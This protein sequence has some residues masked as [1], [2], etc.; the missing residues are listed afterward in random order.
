MCSADM[1][2]TSHRITDDEIK[3]ITTRPNREEELNKLSGQI[4]A[5]IELEKK[6]KIN[7]YDKLGYAGVGLFYW[8]YCGCLCTLPIKELDVVH[9]ICFKQG[10]ALLDE[11]K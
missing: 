3:Q 10:Y 6:G 8:I 11:L 1:T 7:L 5:Y 9:A 2:C 4:A